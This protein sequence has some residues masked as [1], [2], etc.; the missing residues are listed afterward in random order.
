MPRSLKKG[1]FVDDHLLKKVDVL[2]EKGQKTVIKTWSR[3]ST[4][5]PDM[6]G[7]TIAVHDGRKHVP[8][9]V[10]ESMVGHKLGEF[11]PTRTFRFHAGQERGEGSALMSTAAHIK[12]NERPGVRAVHRHARFSAYKAREVLDLI[13]GKSVAEARTILRVH[14]AQRRRVRA[15]G[16]RL[17]RRQRRQQQRHPARGALRHGVLRR[18][19]A[20]AASASAPGPAAVRPASASGPATSRSSSAA[21][22]STSWTRPL[23]SGRHRSSLR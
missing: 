16:A 10:T 5:I 17:G 15:E 19:G 3:R 1:P 8:V 11:A 13:R 20:D 9:Y 22:R 4:I 14:R 21:T 7:H 12:T 23:P 18:R 2:N 6:V